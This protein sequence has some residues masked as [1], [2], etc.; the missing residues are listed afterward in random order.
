MDGDCA[1]GDRGGGDGKHSSAAVF[2]ERDEEEV[3]LLFGTFTF[4]FDHFSGEGE[5]RVKTPD[6]PSAE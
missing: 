6:Q 5:P 1:G 4:R 2:G 3:V